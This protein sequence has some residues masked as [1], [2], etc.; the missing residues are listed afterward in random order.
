MTKTQKF[1]LFALAFII[2]II[3]LHNNPAQSQQCAGFMAESNK[4]VSNPLSDKNVNGNTLQLC[5][6][7]PSTGFGRNGFYQAGTQDTGTHIACAILSKEFLEFSK[8][9]GN[10]LMTPRPD[11]AFPGLKAGD[12]WCL[13]ADRWTEALKAG[14]AP[15]LVLEATHEKMIDYSDIEIL[16]HYAHQPSENASEFTMS[17]ASA[18]QFSFTSIDGNPLPLSQFTGKV[19]LVVNTASQC[20][21][22]K[23]YKD[24]E[25]LYKK[26][27]DKGLIVIGVPCNQFGSQEPGSE[28]TIKKFAEKEYGVTFPLTSKTEITGKNA[29]P[30]FVW[31]SAQNKGGFLRS[32]PKWNLHKFLIDRHGQLAMSFSSYVDP[33]D[34]AVTQQIESLLNETY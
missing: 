20:G 27:K 8:T 4:Q 16:Q 25:S 5:G 19:I 18:Y 32:S 13:C 9:H 34:P 7:N 15:N 21:F 6:N 23:Q 1:H 24:L 12:H 10:D 22:T 28:T 17:K 31:A 29:H 26:Y 11:Y 3:S 14:V 30:F 33:A 2:M